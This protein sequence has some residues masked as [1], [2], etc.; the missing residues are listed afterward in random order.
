MPAM[1]YLTAPMRV[2]SGF[3]GSTVSECFPSVFFFFSFLL[4]TFS[5][6]CLR[7]LG[8]NDSLCFLG[9]REHKL[10]FKARP[11]GAGQRLPALEQKR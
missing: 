8:V 10:W 6:C 2:E 5:L 7:A 3:S 9:E 4:Q 1:K 11:R